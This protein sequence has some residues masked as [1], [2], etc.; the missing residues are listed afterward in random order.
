V[1]RQYQPKRFFREVP[2]RS[3]QEYFQ[4]HNLLSTV[5]FSELTETQ[6]DPI[7]DAWLGL[8]DVQRNELE[9]DFQEIDELAT[10]AGSK[11][12]LDEARWHGEDLAAQ[13]A[14]LNGFH[15]HAFWTFLQRQKYWRG[16]VAFNHA[17]TIPSSYWR[18]RKNLPH[19][20]AAVDADSIKLL[21]QSISHH[22]HTA[23]G[24]GHNCKV[25]CFRRDDLDYFFAYPEDYAQARVEWEGNDI[26][27]RARHPAFEIIF[28]F[29]QV[30]G[31]LDI[32]LTGDRSPVK[33]LQ[34]IF[35]A[36]ILQ[37]E[38]GPDSKD[39]LVYDLNPLRSRNFEFLFTPESGIADV[40]VTKLRLK[41]VGK[42]ER[43]VL[44]SDP[45]KNEHA[46]FD[47]LDKVTTVIPLSQVV[48]T[49]VGLRVTFASN[50]DSKRPST[51]TFDVGSPNSCSLKHSERDLRIRRML[52]ESGIEPQ[53]QVAANKIS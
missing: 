19:R 6:I 26:A 33:D 41:V 40:R 28:V 35:A 39:E 17:D 16:S 14:S 25:D 10:E 52:A 48:I 1:A 3:L 32:F 47:L 7:Y 27:R 31:T 43:L 13:F 29:S 45:T 44:E 12:I 2:N 37:A 20:P 22:F 46:V 38:L 15:E 4:H 49:Q 53:P 8:S 42:N 50:P 23:Q 51:R 34:A 30:A 18:K 9:Q 36:T 24:R 11:A 21:E 5:P